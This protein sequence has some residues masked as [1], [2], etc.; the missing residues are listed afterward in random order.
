MRRPLLGLGLAAM[1][2]IGLAVAAAMTGRKA[3]PVRPDRLARQ[4]RRSSGPNAVILT[5]TTDPQTFANLKITAKV[6]SVSSPGRRWSTSRLPTTRQADRRLRPDVEERDG[7]PGQLPEPGL[8]YGQ[9][10]PGASGSPA[11]G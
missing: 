10:G 1:L 3:R 5:P 8:L 9:T 4:A 6:T 11:S 2:V 7:D